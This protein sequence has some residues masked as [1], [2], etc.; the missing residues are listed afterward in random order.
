[1]GSISNTLI[2]PGTGYG[3]PTD[4]T[5]FWHTDLEVVVQPRKTCVITGVNSPKYNLDIF[6]KMDYY[7]KRFLSAGPAS[8]VWEKVP[9]SFAV[10]WFVDL[11]SYIDALDNV[12]TGSTSKIHSISL[13]NHWAARFG[14]VRHSNSNWNS[15]LDGQ[16]TAFNRLSYYHRK[17][18]MDS[19]SATPAGRFGKNQ[20]AL[21][22]ALLHQ[23]VA[24]LKR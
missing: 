15:T 21:S 13:S 23:L 3:Q 20:I 8:L 2:S 18:Y 10:D 24:N 17:P 22:G 12:L 7:A 16:E 9:W 4:G 14:V 6:N 11:S 1:M 19:L 5:S